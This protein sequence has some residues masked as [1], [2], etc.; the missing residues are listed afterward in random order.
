MSAPIFH[1]LTFLVAPHSDPY[2]IADVQVASLSRACRSPH[3]HIHNDV[4]QSTHACYFN[5]ETRGHNQA[6][7]IVS[8]LLLGVVCYNKSSKPTFLIYI[9]FGDVQCLRF[10]AIQNPSWTSAGCVTK[11]ML[12]VCGRWYVLDVKFGGKKM[13]ER[14]LNWYGRVMRREEHTLRKMMKMDI[15]GKRKRGRPKLRCKRDLKGTQERARRRTGQH[16]VDRSSVIPATLYDGKREG[17]RRRQQH[18][19]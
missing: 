9:F 12:L 7:I 18:K 2:V 5:T 8:Y 10:T 19:H 3:H 4:K 16:G 14:R 13:T 1:C 15:P 6:S 11:W 17:K